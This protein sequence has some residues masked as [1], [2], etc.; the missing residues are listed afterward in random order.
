M[1]REPPE[2]GEAVA[3]PC[4]RLAWPQRP[5]PCLGREQPRLPE[6]GQVV[7]SRW[8]PPGDP[9]GSAEA[10]S[11]EPGSEDAPAA[12]PLPLPLKPPFLRPPS[13]PCP[14]HRA[15]SLLT[16]ALR[17]IAAAAHGPRSSPAELGSSSQHLLRERKASAP[18]HSSQPTLFTF[19]P[20][21]PAHAQPALSTSAPQE[22][23]YL[24]QCI[25]R[26][27]ENAR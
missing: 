2:R 22:Y 24:H 8:W 13:L 16:D 6:A 18:S 14:S 20:S 27:A 9:R 7:P 1:P 19:E 26:R 4:P 17:N 25:S 3:F 21:L 15:S 10:L 5:G 12:G 23:L 11:Q